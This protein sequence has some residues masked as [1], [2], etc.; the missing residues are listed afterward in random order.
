MHMLL[1]CC[2]ATAAKAIASSST[3]RVVV[4]QLFHHRFAYAS[5]IH[6]ADPGHPAFYRPLPRVAATHG[7][8]AIC[9]DVGLPTEP[10]FDQ[11]FRQIAPDFNR[12]LFVP[13]N[14]EMDCSSVRDAHKVEEYRPIVMDVLSRF[15]N[16]VLLDNAVAK[17]VGE[18]GG[19]GG[20]TTWF[21]GT[22]LWSR[23]V[24]QKPTTTTARRAAAIAESNARH[25]EDVRW[26][27]SALDDIAAA[28]AAPSDM[29]VVLSHFPPTERLIESKYRACPAHHQTGRFWTNLESEFMGEEGIVD[30]W[31]AGHSHTHDMRCTVGNVDCRVHS[32][33]L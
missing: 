27:H 24:P 25:A 28:T 26:L 16:V 31:I 4:P 5:D 30:G 10:R 33:H 6:A 15:P 13:G 29:V 11:F 7:T 14:H 21:A 32:K 20:G 12:I 22:T 9:G 1:Q 8:L 2:V 23:I 3:T 18:G 17:V 19:S